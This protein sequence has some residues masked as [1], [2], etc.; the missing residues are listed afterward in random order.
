M[1]E[2]ALSKYTRNFISEISKCRLFALR[3]FQKYVCCI[4]LNLPYN[5]RKIMIK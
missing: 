3:R 1:E 4:I 2:G 5:D